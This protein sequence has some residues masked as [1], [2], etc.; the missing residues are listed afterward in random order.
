MIRK[1]DVRHQ[2]QL[3]VLVE[4]QPSEPQRRRPKPSIPKASDAIGVVDVQLGADRAEGFAGD[5][6]RSAA[7]PPAF[8]LSCEGEI[9]FANPPGTRLLELDA[10][11]V[12]RSLSTAI[13]NGWTDLPWSVT[14]LQGGGGV[15]VFL[16][17]SKPP[18][19]EPAT[20]E[21]VE[22]AAARWNLTSRQRQVLDLVA[23]GLTNI[24][25]ARLLGITR[26]TVEFHL[27]GI[28]DKVGV[29]NRATLIVRLLEMSSNDN[30]G[31][32]Q[33][34]LPNPDSRSV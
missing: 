25:T 19:R 30:P 28:F 13:C 16:A 26:S 29:D 14:C 10:T 18:R 27:S 22:I 33:A 11:E 7:E 21:A 17:I 23:H 9:L 15:K 31:P 2:S 6:Q 20:V 5:P 3:G 1:I 32:V 8:V 12:R 24:D 34:S 4:G